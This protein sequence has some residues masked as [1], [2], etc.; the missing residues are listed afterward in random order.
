[1]QAMI[2]HI[3]DPNLGDPM[4]YIQWNLDLTV[5]MQGRVSDFYDE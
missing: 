1:M 3:D 5:I 2:L 4:P